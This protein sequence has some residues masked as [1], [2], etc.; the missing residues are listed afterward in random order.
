MGGMQSF[1]KEDAYRMAG[2]VSK[3]FD[4]FPM[5]PTKPGEFI[6]R[7]GC[8]QGQIGGGFQW[9]TERPNSEFMKADKNCLA[10]LLATGAH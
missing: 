7:G 6:D 9:N 10:R 1:H 4:I 8:M 5:L 3:S 2:Q